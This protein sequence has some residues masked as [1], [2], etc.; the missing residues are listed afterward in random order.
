MEVLEQLKWHRA[1]NPN[2]IRR[3]SQRGLGLV[4]S[5]Y[6]HSP[7]NLRAGLHPCRVSRRTID[8]RRVVRRIRRGR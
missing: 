4:V 8:A 6:S 7:C 1:G 2:L 3:L 5:E